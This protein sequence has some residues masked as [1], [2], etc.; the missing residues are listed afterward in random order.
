VTYAI[1]SADF[2]ERLT[3]GMYK[4]CNSVP[5]DKAL[6]E[7]VRALGAKAKIEGQERPVYLR[8][9]GHD[10]KVYLNL[11][12]DEGRVV[13]I[14][15]E[16]WRVVTDPPVRFVRTKTMRALPVPADGG[17][18]LQLRDV[19][20]VS[21]DEDWMKVVALILSFL[22]PEG[23][24]PV[25]QVYGPHGSAKS[26]ACEIIRSTVDPNDPAHTGM[27][28]KVEDLLLTALHNGVVVVDNVS[29][30]SQK[31]SDALCRLSTGGGIEKRKLYS[32]DET[33]VIRVCRPVLF[34][35]I[36]RDVVERPDL[37]SRLLPIGLCSLEGKYK[38]TSQV[39]SAFRGMHA[40][41]LGAL[42]TL[43]STGLRNR[44]DARDP[45]LR[46]PDFVA[47]VEACAPDLGWPAGKFTEVFKQAGKETE[48]LAL[49]NWP[50][51]EVL[52]EYLQ[53]HG[54]VFHGTVGGLLKALTAI[55]P[56]EYAHANTWPRSARA[57]GGELSRYAPNLKRY[58]VTVDRGGKGKAG[59][60]VEVT[61]DGTTSLD[62]GA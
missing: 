39:H 30:I 50:V 22:M 8:V 4:A 7:A 51:A 13:E 19:L 35:G 45:D 57:L 21:D 62:M 11:A 15:T 3:Y 26:T 14:D 33:H 1:Y 48:S 40:S 38:G 56:A 24:Y 5:Q 52:F 37:G 42:C 32:D 61:W 53:K 29:A 27:P 36:Q 47:W 59:F 34:N 43:A 2:K 6:T 28:E 41:V 20:N 17:N 46:M 55:M 49:A 25:G 44:T 58:G 31:L 10:G 54:G 60:R 12:D 23:P 9:A 18:L 16:G